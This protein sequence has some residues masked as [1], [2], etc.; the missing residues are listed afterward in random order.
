[1]VVITI[2]VKNP[3]IIGFLGVVEVTSVNFLSKIGLIVLV[4]LVTKRR[5][6][7]MESGRS[8]DAI[9]VSP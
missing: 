5:P 2:E 6:M 3:T 4:T 1:M 7:V 9:S 8:L